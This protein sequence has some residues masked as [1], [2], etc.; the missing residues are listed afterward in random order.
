MCDRFSGK[1]DPLFRVKNSM[2]LATIN[3]TNKKQS[4]IND[5]DGKIYGCSRVQGPSIFHLPAPCI[6]FHIGRMVLKDPD[7]FVQVPISSI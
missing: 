4:H 1:E 6:C 7:I 3:I 5:D 2:L